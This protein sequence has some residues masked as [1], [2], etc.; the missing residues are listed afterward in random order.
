MSTTP[1]ETLVDSLADLLLSWT[2][3]SREA[4]RAFVEEH[5][6]VSPPL[7]MFLCESERLVLRPDQPYIFRVDKTC[8][9]CVRIANDGRIP[10]EPIDVEEGE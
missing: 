10:G 1:N 9:A 8:S 2:G 6:L 4:A 7:E 5:R 3:D